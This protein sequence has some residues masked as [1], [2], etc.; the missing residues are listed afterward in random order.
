MDNQHTQW[1]SILTLTLTLTLTAHADTNQ[2]TQKSQKSVLNN[3]NKNIATIKADLQNATNKKTHLQDALDYIE[4]TQGHLNQQLKKTQTQLSA[5]QIQL[6]QLQ[7]K[8]TPLLKK[9]NQARELLKQQ[10]RAAYLFSHQPYLKL[11]LAPNGITQTRRLLMYFHYITQIQLNT[12]T[13]LQ[14]SI[15]QYKQNQQ[16][17]QNQYKK[18]LTVKQTQLDNQQAM[19]KTKVARQQLIQT[20]DQNIKTKSEKLTELL[21]DKKRLQKTLE[22]LNNQMTEHWS[23]AVL[24]NK[25][26]AQLK[27]KLPW[28]THGHVLHNFGTQIKQSE[29]RWDGM[30]I[31][32]P[33]GQPVHAVASGQVIFAKWLAGYGLLMIVNQGNG[34]MTLYGRNQSLMKKVG[35]RVLAGEEI[36]TVGKSGG[37]HQPALYFAI[38]H[39][40]QVLNP[41]TWCRSVFLTGS[42]G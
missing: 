38:R 30:L 18:L 32:A 3:L 41:N 21:S 16:A 34:Y 39:N 5:Q 22:N 33:A 29:L 37:F 24:N 25:P 14:Q 1:K 40:T 15:L 13:Q 8:S 27:G 2:T 36:A 11:L 20:I 17:I 26:F 35:D 7:K 9:E 23:A 10:I 42:H 31:E 12:I 19:Q 6:T 28:P 4:T